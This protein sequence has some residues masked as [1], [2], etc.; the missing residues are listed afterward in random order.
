MLSGHCCQRDTVCSLKLHQSL[1]HNIQIQRRHLH[2]ISA[3]S[4]VDRE[5]LLG[6]GQLTGRCQQ[7]QPRG[8]CCAPDWRMSALT[9]LQVLLVVPGLF[10]F[11]H[12]LLHSAWAQHGAAAEP[13]GNE[14]LYVNN[15]AP[16]RAGCG[17]AAAAPSARAQAPLSRGL[18]CA[19]ASTCF[20]CFLGHS[21]LSLSSPHLHP[22]PAHPGGLQSIRCFSLCCSRAAFRRGSSDVAKAAFPLP[23]L[24]MEPRCLQVPLG[25][26]ERSFR[27]KA[28]SSVF[29]HQALH[30]EHIALNYTYLESYAM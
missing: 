14:P 5:P 4:L 13:R 25:N 11:G 27:Q 9:L 8:C 17:K 1:T 30:C 29:I 24:Q 19:A 20:L 7:L 18:L 6:G 10:L 15:R 26:C 28:K 3:V 16:A 22:A 23:C 21:H 2:D 12:K